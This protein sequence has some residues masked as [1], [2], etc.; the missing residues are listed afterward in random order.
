MTNWYRNR[1]GR[2]TALVPWR[3]VDDWGMTHDIDLDDF[4]LQRT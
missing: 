3:L 2:N 1:N 4:H